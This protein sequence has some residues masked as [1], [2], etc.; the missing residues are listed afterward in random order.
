MPSW[1]ALKPLELQCAELSFR[2]LRRAQLRL[3]L[4]LALLPSGH[5]V[6]VPLAVSGEHKEGCPNISLN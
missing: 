5:F 6:A 1:S 2:Q 4:P 3:K